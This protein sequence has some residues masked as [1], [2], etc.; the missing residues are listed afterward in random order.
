MT[1]GKPFGPFRLLARADPWHGCAGS[2]GSG[3]V[4]AVALKS[5]GC[6]IACVGPGDCWAFPLPGIAG[7]LGKALIA[8]GDLACKLL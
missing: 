2:A 5:L 1:C 7:R 6:L 3:A 8:A 4:R